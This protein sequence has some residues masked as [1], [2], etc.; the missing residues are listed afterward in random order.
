M[1]AATAGAIAVEF[2]PYLRDFDEEVDDD[3]KGYF[4]VVYLGALISLIAIVSVRLLWV[5]RS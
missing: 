5:R 3:E 1:C 4:I 2:T